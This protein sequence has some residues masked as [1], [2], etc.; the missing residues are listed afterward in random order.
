MY[1]LIA[2][3]VR[4]E[5]LSESDAPEFV[6]YRQIPD[7]ARW[8]SWTTAYSTTDALALIRTQPRGVVPPPGEW[9]QLAVHSTDAGV[10]YGDIALHPLEGEPATYEVG[11]TFAPGFQGRGLA[12]E[13]L[14]RVLEFLFHDQHAHRVVA[15]CDTR[16]AAVATL[17]RRLNF[18]QESHQIDADF[19][20]DEWTT[21]DGY[22]LL[23]SDWNTV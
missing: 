1:P 3:R 17:L 4:I 8:Q 10:L 13:A 9:L 16:N 12:T 14:E 7:I 2:D 20:K 11:I 15:F 23:A 5:P 18:R 21:V 6:V 22:A 19:L